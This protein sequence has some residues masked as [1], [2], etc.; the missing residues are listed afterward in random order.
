[1]KKILT[2]LLLIGGSSVCFSQ[3]SIQH[4]FSTITSS[5]SKSVSYK[6][7]QSAISELKLL[8]K[9]T[10]TTDFNKTLVV[11]TYLLNQTENRENKT[12]GLNILLDFAAGNPKV[13]GGQVIPIVKRVARDVYDSA[14]LIKLT[15][16]LTNP[17]NPSIPEALKVAGYVGGE[18]LHRFLQQQDSI[19]TK[20]KRT[21]WPYALA[22]A[23][24]GDAAW[25]TYCTEK[26]KRLEVN[27]QSIYFLYPDLAYT[28]QKEAIDY[29]VSVLLNN[30]YTCDSPNPES[31][32]KID[33][34]YRLMEI[35][36][37]VVN[38]FPFK[39]GASGDLTVS[40][41]KKA[42]AEIREWFK[43][44]NGSYTIN[45]NI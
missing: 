22:M 40:D 18:E 44:K 11:T 43:Q 24:M 3:K 31:S 5:P 9:D 37:P 42:L 25:I 35:L 38:D 2:L 13:F 23:R 21:K 1:M 20:A 33:C 14:S 45:T 17:N 19:Y 36:A 6:E 15:V 27:T 12:I 30:S 8:R 7:L 41:Y 10:L 4:V 26:V 29:L 28:R 16:Y 34:G 32:D 39:V